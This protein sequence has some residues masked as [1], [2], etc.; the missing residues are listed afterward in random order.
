MKGKPIPPNRRWHS[1][2]V[3]QKV[4]FLEAGRAIPPPS[5]PQPPPPP[6]LH[7]IL[8][9]LVRLALIVTLARGISSLIDSQVP[10]ST[11]SDYPKPV[12]SSR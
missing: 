2:T 6:L 12:I 7:R 5:R 4:W 11:P 3:R 10:P 8:A 1:E 9:Q